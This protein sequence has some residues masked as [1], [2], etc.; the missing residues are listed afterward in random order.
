MKMIRIQP[1]QVREVESTQEGSRCFLVTSRDGEHTHEVR[2]VGEGEPD[3]RV[4]GFLGVQH[5]TRRI[6]ARLR[7]Q[8]RRVT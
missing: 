3:A 2:Y 4:V 7:K 8:R 5:I 6:S 1:V